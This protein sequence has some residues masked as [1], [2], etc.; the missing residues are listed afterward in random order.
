MS[1]H[2]YKELIKERRGVVRAGAGFGV[3]LHGKYVTVLVTNA[4]AA[5]VVDIGVAHFGDSGINALFVHD[6]A[7]IL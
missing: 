6:I 1:S 5:A 2:H 3:E 7:V 4:L